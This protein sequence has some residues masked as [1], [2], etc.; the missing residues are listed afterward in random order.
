MCDGVSLNLY[1]Q[2]KQNK[3]QLHWQNNPCRSAD[4]FRVWTKMPVCFAFSNGT[5]AKKSGKIY[6]CIT[7]KLKISFK[8]S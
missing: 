2:T 5:T 7:F 6:D 4:V 8:N 3:K 1:M